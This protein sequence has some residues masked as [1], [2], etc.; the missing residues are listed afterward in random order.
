[1]FT[2]SSLPGHSQRATWSIPNP[3]P[4]GG[5]P[6]RRAVELEERRA[7]GSEGSCRRE[8]DGRARADLGGAH[9]D[10]LER[11]VR[12][13]VAVALLVRPV[14]A[15]REIGAEGDCQLERLA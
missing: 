11:P 3:H 2:P 10:E 14:E 6:G 15:L 9:G 7:L 8:V 12:V 13:G 5:N 1:M 4:P